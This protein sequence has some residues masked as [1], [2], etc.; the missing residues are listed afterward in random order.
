MTR[1][2]FRN[3]ASRGR[4]YSVYVDRF[5]TDVGT[6][7]VVEWFDALQDA[8]DAAD[9]MKADGRFYGIHIYVRSQ[10]FANSPIAA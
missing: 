5:I 6:Q 8:M 9:E 1:Y 2:Q 3:N 4:R 10:E 7:P